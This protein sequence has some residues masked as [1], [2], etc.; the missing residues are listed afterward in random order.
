AQTL[1]RSRLESTN[2]HMKKT[3]FNAY[4]CF[5]PQGHY[6]AFL[7]PTASIFL[8]DHAKKVLPHW[9]TAGLKG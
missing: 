8:A 3:F 1:T 4:G 7:L 2:T 6:T 5:Q 9:D